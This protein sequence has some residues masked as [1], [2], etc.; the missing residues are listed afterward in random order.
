MI[1]KILRIVG[2]VITLAALFWGLRFFRLYFFAILL[3]FFILFPFVSVLL[4]RYVIRRT[5]Y[6][7]HL[8]DVITKGADLEVTIGMRNPTIFPI[9]KHLLDLKISNLFYPNDDIHTIWTGLRIRSE[10]TVTIP[11]SILYSG[12]LQVSL[13]QIRIP[14]YL[15][16]IT[17]RRNSELKKDILV[18]PI[19]L[20]DRFSTMAVG[21][22]GNVEL[23]ESDVVGNDATQMI[24]VLEYRPGDRLNTIH[25]KLSVKAGEIMVKQFGS[26]SDNDACILLDLYRPKVQNKRVYKDKEDAQADLIEG[27]DS[28]F[29]MLETLA[30]Q[31]LSEKRPILVCWYSQR[32]TE[33][34][35]ME[36]TRRS[37]LNDVYRILFYEEPVADPMIT[38]EYFTK[39][40]DNYRDFFYIHSV[41]QNV[42]FNHTFLFGNDIETVS[43]V[44]RD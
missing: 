28:A 1:K 27:F 16:F 5:E 30:S 8:P 14:D 23:S 21:G 13:S 9:P 17:F 26:L 25:W 2:Y 19:R 39:T 10:Q 40:D 32:M 22:S 44:H 29:D 18:L 36:V 31:L 3:F 15:N 11:L 41:S 12:Y 38:F 4:A 43:V 42:T 7:W 35:S 33:L 20:N 37:D 34:K 6:F 24:D